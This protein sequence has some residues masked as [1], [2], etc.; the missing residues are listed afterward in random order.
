MRC[1]STY[2][3]IGLLLLESDSCDCNRVFVPARTQVMVDSVLAIGRGS[4]TA[5]LMKSPCLTIPATKRHCCIVFWRHD[6]GTTSLS[7]HVDVT[8]LGYFER[9]GRTERG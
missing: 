5:I 2:L 8:R 1:E 6:N 9:G 4:R 7:A 3:V